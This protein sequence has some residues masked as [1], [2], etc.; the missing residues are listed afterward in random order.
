MIFEKND[1]MKDYLYI[2]SFDDGHQTRF[3]VS[4]TP[5]IDYLI[6]EKQF[7][8]ALIEIDKL[9]KTD[10]SYSNLNLKGIILQN[11][12]RFDESLECF[13]NA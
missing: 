13:D 11:L 1:I 8:K 3:K 7:D 12:G 10:Y 4:D 2:D 5:K 9:L 6:K